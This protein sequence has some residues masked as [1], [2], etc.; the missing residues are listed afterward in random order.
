MKTATTTTSTTVD[1]FALCD[2]FR[3]A[4]ANETRVKTN[5]GEEEPLRE[6][7]AE[8]EDEVGA[9]GRVDDGHTF[10]RAWCALRAW[11]EREDGSARVDEFHS[12][13]VDLRGAKEARFSCLVAALM[14]VQCLD[15]VALKAF[16][17]L[18]AD[19]L[20]G[21]VT[22]VGIRALKRGELERACQT[23]N[24]WRAKAKYIAECA[25]I[26]HFKFRDRVP[27]TVG[28]LKTL[29][30]VGD[31]L[32]HLIA[33]VA[34]DETPGVFSGV[35]VDTHVLRVSKRLGWVNQSDDAESARM[36]LQSRVHRDDWDDLTQ[37]LIALGQNVCRARTPA[38][39]SCPLHEACPSGHRAR[40]ETSRDR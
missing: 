18:R 35:V 13:L 6:R 22:I 24:L 37:S 31:K 15:K 21:H 19:V 2:G 16:E 29:P 36:A 4:N 27:R 40:A 39:A 38:C 10:T 30:G 20:G 32:A 17:K 8:D 25:D 7:E 3:L 23:L 14:S 5:A 11:R 33:S 1:F 9:S 12:F 34:Y 28:A 26:I